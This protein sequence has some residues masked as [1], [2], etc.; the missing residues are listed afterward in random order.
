[1]SIA[2]AKRLEALRREM[3]SDVDVALDPSELEGLDDDA[4]RRW[5]AAPRALKRVPHLL[6][7]HALL[8]ALLPSHACPPACPNLDSL[9]E[10]RLA[11]QRAAAGREDF[12]DLVAAKAAQQK[13]KQAEKAKAEAKKFKF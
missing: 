9:Y 6:L 3:P 12:S 13:R 4:L 1:M 11:E 2:A 7:L 8:I 10:A 5:A